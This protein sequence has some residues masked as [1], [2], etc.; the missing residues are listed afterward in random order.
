M[1]PLIWTDKA[2]KAC[3]DI[4]EAIGGCQLLSFVQT[5][6][7]GKESLVILYTDASLY[8]MGGVLHQVIEGK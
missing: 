6:E 4:Q 1:K 5:A 7:L 3:A 8:G 2:I